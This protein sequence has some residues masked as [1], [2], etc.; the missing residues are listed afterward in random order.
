MN[1]YVCASR[2]FH[3]I[4]GVGNGTVVVYAD[5]CSTC[6]AKVSPSTIVPAPNG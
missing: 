3:C 5:H 1:L 6:G 2:G 4:G